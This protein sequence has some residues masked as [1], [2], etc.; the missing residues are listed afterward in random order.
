MGQVNE[1]A[2]HMLPGEEQHEKSSDRLVT[3]DS[4]NMAEVVSVEYLEHGQCS[5]HTHPHDLQLKIGALET[6]IRNI[7]SDKGLDNC[8]NEVSRTRPV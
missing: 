4:E 5:R 6:F 3:Y 1:Y 2:F 7:D 8:K